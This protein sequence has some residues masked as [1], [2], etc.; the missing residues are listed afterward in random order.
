MSKCVCSGMEYLAT[1]GFV[2]RVSHRIQQRWV[3][4]TAPFVLYDANLCCCF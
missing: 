4:A 2:H 1:V 3:G